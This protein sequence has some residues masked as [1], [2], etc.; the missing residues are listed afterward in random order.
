M[1]DGSATSHQLWPKLATTLREGYRLDAFRRDAVAALTVAI[2]ALPLSMAIA[3]ASGV[4]PDRGL[5]AAII[6]GFIV[7][8]DRL[9]PRLVHSDGEP[10]LASL[11]V[12]Y[13][14]NTPFATSDV[15]RNVASM[16][17]SRYCHWCR[18]RW[19]G[20]SR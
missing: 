16:R 18:R 8:T 14:V 13:F 1:P 11:H 17:S 6:G 3:V 15:F 5:Y 19:P 20:T 4:S 7:S 12:F 2:V 9:D 10:Y